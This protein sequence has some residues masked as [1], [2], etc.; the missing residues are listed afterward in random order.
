MV[1]EAEVSAEPDDGRV[2]SSN[3]GQ[4]SYN[5]VHLA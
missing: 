3:V 1:R 5:I 2:P 4:H